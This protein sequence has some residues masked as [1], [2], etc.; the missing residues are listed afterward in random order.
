[1]PDGSIGEDHH[2]ETH[3]IP[4][5]LQ[6]AA[7]TRDGLQIFGDDYPTKDGTTSATMCMSLT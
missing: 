2:P 6:A 5:I 1:M 7:G 3:L 4:I